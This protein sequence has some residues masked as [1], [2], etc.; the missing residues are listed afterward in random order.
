MNNVDTNAQQSNNSVLWAY[1]IEPSIKATAIDITDVI[2]G[3]QI[4]GFTWVHMQCDAKGA[5]ETM[6]SL[7]LSQQVIESLEAV[8]T[9]PK[10]IAINDGL[11][12]YL[13]GINKNPDADPEDMV[14]LRIWIT[15]KGII[16]ARRKGRKLLSVQ[17]V[18]EQLDI[19]N[20]PIN[21]AQ[22][23]LDI[24][25]RI[26]DRI[27]EMVDDLDEQLVAF[28]TT[29]HMNSQARQKLSVV[30]R[31]AAAIRRYLAPQR[32]ALDALYRFNKLLSSDQAFQLREKTDRMTRYVEDLDLARERSIVLQDEVRNRLAEQQGAKM[33]VLS[34]VTAIF[35]PLSF[36]TGVFGMNVAGLPGIE[37]PNAFNYLASGM[38]GLALVLFTLMMWKKW[39]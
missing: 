28:E 3:Q 30:R 31:Q 7:G 26:A 1:Y 34:L 10:T 19:G 37:E 39:F 27:H 16:S 14:S 8:E 18:R 6:A 38:I 17:D 25:E 11:L 13:R 20:I 5:K 21:A 35:L 15:D 9:R 33:Y 36:L 4:G 29:E 23:M 22:L 12:V 2:K 32:D 24:I